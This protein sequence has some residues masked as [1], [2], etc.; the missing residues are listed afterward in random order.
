MR[1]IEREVADLVSDNRKYKVKRKNV[2][3]HWDTNR[4]GQI[5]ILFDYGK[6]DNRSVYF[7]KKLLKLSQT[8]EAYLLKPLICMDFFGPY[9]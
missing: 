9:V 5:I 1:K 8:S 2:F 6:N 3:A 4:I 7:P